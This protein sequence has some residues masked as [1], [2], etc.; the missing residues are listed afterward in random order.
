M[1]N[2]WFSFLS[3]SI[4]YS[5]A[6]FKWRRFGFHQH[7]RTWG[8]VWDEILILNQLKEQGWPLA[9]W[10]FLSKQDKEPANYIIIHCRLACNCGIWCFL[11]LEFWA[12]S[13]CQLRKYKQ[14]CR[15]LGGW[16]LLA[17]CNLFGKS[18]IE[19]VLRGWRIWSGF[20]FFIGKISR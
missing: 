15:G 17:W 19:D 14:F 2:Y 5:R 9:G 16:H 4:Q 11:C 13:L 1:A 6:P 12:C 18:R 10:C 7:P 20:F 3:A 8:P